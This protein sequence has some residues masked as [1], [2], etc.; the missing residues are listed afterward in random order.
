MMRAATVLDNDVCILRFSPNLHP[1]HHRSLFLRD[2]TAKFYAASVIIAFDYMHSLN[3]V[4]RD[5]K[6]VS[7]SFSLST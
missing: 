3:V 6:P 2:Q 7:F 4:Y 5:L 1:Y